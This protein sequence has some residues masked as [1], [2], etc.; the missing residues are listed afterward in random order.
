VGSLLVLPLLEL[1]SSIGQCDDWNDV[2]ASF[3]AQ[4]S[5]WHNIPSARKIVA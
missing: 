3:Q 1:L 5:K 4:S 2:C